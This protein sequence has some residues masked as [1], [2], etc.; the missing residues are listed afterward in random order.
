MRG[1]EREWA[2]DREGKTDRPT[3]RWTDKQNGRDRK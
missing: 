2:I 3:D 1:R